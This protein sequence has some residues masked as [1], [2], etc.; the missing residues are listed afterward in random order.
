MS[1]KRIIIGKNPKRTLIRAVIIAI[2]CI[3]L[4]KCFLIP[5][6][7]NGISMEP[8]YR[9]GSVN[10]VNALY[11]NSR[12]IK[13]GDIVTIAI[14]SGREYMYL[15]RVVGFPGERVSFRR[16][17]LLIDGKVVSEPY[18]KY[19]YN[20]DMPEVLVGENEYFVVGDNRRIPIETHKMGRV[21]KDRIVGK[22]LW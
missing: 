19:E 5:V 15:K 7:I 4:F 14:G 1:V 8:T 22:P 13:R 2:F 11:Y 21:D 17:R 10:L 12:E 9:D 20:W 18:I 6:K 3:I 16:G